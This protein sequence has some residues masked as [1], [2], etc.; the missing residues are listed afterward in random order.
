MQAH[1]L[2]AELATHNHKLHSF[3]ASLKTAK[4]MSGFGKKFLSAFIETEDDADKE[5]DSVVSS[6]PASS[7]APSP[8]HSEKFSSYF[9]KLFQDSNMPGPDYYEFSKMVEAMQSIPDE[10]TRY[11]SA[12]AGLSVQGL[13]KEKLLQ[14]AKKYIEIL[15]ADSKDFNTSIN[16][17][18]QEKVEMKKKE[19]EDKSKKIQELTRDINDLNNSIQVLGNDI[20]D[21]EEKIRSNIS[22]YTAESER[23][24]SKIQQDIQ[25]IGSLL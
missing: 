23:F 20:R 2:P 25:K 12:F 8:G 22:G 21:N 16:K 1:I 6:S 15:D 5:K 18:L 19:L 9:S 14:T 17:A 4:L 7:S 11:I 24:K 13:D 10:K 3:I